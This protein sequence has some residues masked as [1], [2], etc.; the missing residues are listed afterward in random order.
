MYCIKCGIKKSGVQNAC[1][2]C[3]GTCFKEAGEF[4]TLTHDNVNPCAK[5]GTIDKILD[6]D[7]SF[8][9]CAQCGGSAFLDPNKGMKFDQGKTEWT[10]LPFDAI[11]AIAKVMMMGAKKYE[12]HNWLTVDPP[13]RY[14][15][16]AFRHLT[17][18]CDG[19]RNDSESGHSHLWHVGCCIIFAIHLELAGKLSPEKKEQI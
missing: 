13:R 9:I 1:G 6:E 5:C 18:W 11:E 2:T 12:R 16:A 3:G 4:T 10:L 17:A 8:L 7:T 19:E 14:I 15:D